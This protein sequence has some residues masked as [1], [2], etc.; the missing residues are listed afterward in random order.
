MHLVE[1]TNKEQTVER[2][3]DV[4]A[5]IIANKLDIPKMEI[6]FRDKQLRK[7]GSWKY[8]AKWESILEEQWMQQNNHEYDFR[9]INLVIPKRKQSI[10]KRL[11]VS[12]TKEDFLDEM[13]I[14]KSC[15]TE[16]ILD[17]DIQNDMF[18]NL[19]K[20]K[21][22]SENALN[23]NS[24]EFDYLEV[25]DCSYLLSL[26]DLERMSSLRKTTE[27][28]AKQ[29]LRDSNRNSNDGINGK[30]NSSLHKPKIVGVVY[31]LRL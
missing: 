6:N 19:K 27:D 26:Q 8:L 5:E 21:C 29:V 25:S 7:A 17:T 16:C 23:R 10:K 2:S 1:M 31:K 3:C 4:P 11:N 9:G 18:E 22:V 15:S 24:L 13:Y 28:N 20:K 14:K 12:S 30:R